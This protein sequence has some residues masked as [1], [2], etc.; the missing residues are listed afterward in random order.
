[1]GKQAEEDLHL[2]PA[3]LNISNVV[4]DNGIV[5]GPFLECL[6]QFEIPF[7]DQQLL[8]E[9]IT[10]HEGN[11][12][13]LVNEFLCNGAQQ[14]CFSTARVSEGQDVFRPIQKRAVQKCVEQ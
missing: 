8:N 13:P 5:F 12:P 2:F 14:V 6:R 4:E 9:E 10:G 3:M 11:A 1:M 7:C